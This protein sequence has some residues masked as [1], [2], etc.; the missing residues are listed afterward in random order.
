M[1]KGREGVFGSDWQQDADKKARDGLFGANKHSLS[2][3]HHGEG[4]RI[5]QE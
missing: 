2:T 1:M 4:N 3:L 5:T